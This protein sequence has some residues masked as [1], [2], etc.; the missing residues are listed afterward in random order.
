MGVARDPIFFQKVNNVQVMNHTEAK[1]IELTGNRV[2]EAAAREAG[3]EV[4][5]VLAPAPDKAHFMPEAKPLLL[6]LVVDGKTRRLRGAQAV[7]E[8]TQPDQKCVRSV[9][10]KAAGAEGLTA[11]A[12]SQ[13]T[14][15]TSGMAEDTG[16]DPVAG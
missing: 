16:L 9:Q 3:Y 4:T 8:L 1:E 15:V 6:D 14:F 5:T 10:R 12:V 2:A 13:S 7:G 11:P